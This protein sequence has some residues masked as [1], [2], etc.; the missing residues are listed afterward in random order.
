[1]MPRHEQVKYAL[2]HALRSVDGSLVTVE[3]HIQGTMRRNDIRFVPPPD[4]PL[5]RF[6]VDIT[7]ISLSAPDAL[8]HTT[9]P[10]AP[11]DPIERRQFTIDDYL[12][13]RAK[14]VSII[15]STTRRQR[16]FRP[17]VLTVGGI[18]EKDAEGFLRSWR[19]RMKKS[20]YDFMLRQITDILRELFPFSAISTFVYMTCDLDEGWCEAHYARRL[21]RCPESVSLDHGHLEAIGDCHPLSFK[22]S[23][24][25]AGGAC[26]DCQLSQL[27]IYTTHSSPLHALADKHD[28]RPSWHLSD[29]DQ[30]SLAKG[31]F[32]S[33]SSS[34]SG[35]CYL[36]VSLSGI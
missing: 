29:Q 17:L 33:L 14:R 5:P 27:E 2:A 19:R 16:Y 25:G 10:H 8:H 12:K 24:G 7:V 31:T 3:P 18:L 9:P 4:V 11:T 30:L 15:Y 28:I 34:S 21:L 26:H 35:P 22:N 1:M 36:T 32:W 6:D 20:V 13:T 23:W